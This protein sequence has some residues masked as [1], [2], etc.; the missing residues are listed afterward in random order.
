MDIIRFN[1]H[2]VLTNDRFT[3][4]DTGIGKCIKVLSKH[5]GDIGYKAKAIL[6]QWKRIVRGSEDLGHKKPKPSINHENTSTGFISHPPPTKPN[7]IPTPKHE[8]HDKHD[9]HEI[10]RN[11]HPNNNTSSTS[12]DPMLGFTSRKGKTAVF[13]GQAR[14]FK[15]THV[16]KLE[17]L[18]LRILMD[19]INKISTIGNA[20]YYLMKP[21][22]E[23]CTPSQLFRLEDLNSVCNLLQLNN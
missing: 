12:S 11:I 7:S 10:Q 21:V 20:P 4:Q 22:L 2:F 6:S 15:Y 17:E 3:L 1:G 16:L 5:D 8:K 13:S 14:S 9:K 23:K 19:N 18:C